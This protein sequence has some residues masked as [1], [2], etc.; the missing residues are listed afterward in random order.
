MSSNIKSQAS[1]HRQACDLAGI[2]PWSLAEHLAIRIPKDLYK[3]IA[4]FQRAADVALLALLEL[5]TLYQER[6]TYSWSTIIHLVFAS[7]DRLETCGGVFSQEVWDKYI[8][9]FQAKRFKMYTDLILAMKQ[10]L[11]D[12]DFCWNMKVDGGG[13]LP[14][15]IVDFSKWVTRKTVFLEEMERRLDEVQTPELMQVVAERELMGL[16][17]KFN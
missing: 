8:G 15:A 2:S 4:E 5:E 11:N 16:R 12:L 1:H 6:L 10:R 7:E 3:P 13:L 17:C 14:M 9:I